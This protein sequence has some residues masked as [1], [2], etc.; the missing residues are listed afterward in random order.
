MINGYNS[1]QLIVT[2]LLACISVVAEGSDDDRINL[3]PIVVV[4]GKSPRPLSEV[5]AQVTVI[6]IEEINTGMVEDLDG[7]LK[8]E[9]GLDLE[10]EGT[11]FSASGISIRGIGGNRVAIEIDGV[12]V[13]DRFVIGD[14]SN[15]VGSSFVPL[16]KAIS[17]K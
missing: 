14:F 6:N 5:A 9:P 7:L 8:Y 17:A 3:D 4:A 1:S 11:R 12:P 2:F 10:T 16:S 15:G 13:R